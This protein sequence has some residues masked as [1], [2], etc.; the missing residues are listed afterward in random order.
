MP[1]QP[2]T[3]V[4]VTKGGLGLPVG[5]VWLGHIV[6]RP[7]RLKVGVMKAL[8]LLLWVCQIERGARADVVDVPFRRTSDS[9]PTMVLPSHSRLE[10]G[11]EVDHQ[12]YG[13]TAQ[14]LYGTTRLRY[15]LLF[16]RLIDTGRDSFFETISGTSL[17]SA[18][19]RFSRPLLESFG[20]FGF[21][22]QVL[23]P[24]FDRMT[25]FAP[26]ASSRV[27]DHGRR[28]ELLNR[29]DLFALTTS[30]VGSMD[31]SCRT[32][33]SDDTVPAED[34][35][36]SSTTESQRLRNLLILKVFHDVHVYGAPFHFGSD[37]AWSH[38]L[39]ITPTL[40]P[41]PGQYREITLHAVM[42]LGMERLAEIQSGETPKTLK[43]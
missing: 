2:T 11:F 33:V 9:L 30:F 6:S 17:S 38:S 42:K 32:F 27:L 39:S 37:F 43:P 19:L 14:Q 28:G 15:P 25:W 13:S 3:P 24:F 29:L 5:P 34:V 10:E 16:E 31:R 40:S 41:F 8:F 4:T 20:V 1:R 36:Q 21:P 26:C 35:G 22:T 12:F 23:P 18:S 7:Q